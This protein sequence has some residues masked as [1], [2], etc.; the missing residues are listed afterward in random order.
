MSAIASAGG[1]VWRAPGAI[2]IIRG[3]ERIAAHPKAIRKGTE[4]DPKLQP[5]DTIEVPE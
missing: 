5:G 2:F 4:P 3:T 1:V